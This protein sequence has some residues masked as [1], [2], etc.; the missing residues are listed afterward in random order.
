MHRAWWT[1]HELAPDACARCQGSSY[2]PTAIDGER[3]V[4]KCPKCKGTGKVVTKKAA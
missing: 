4:E 3:I 2:V 1:Q